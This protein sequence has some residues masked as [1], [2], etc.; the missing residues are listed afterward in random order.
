[1]EGLVNS[2]DLERGGEGYGFGG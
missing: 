1:M 2:R